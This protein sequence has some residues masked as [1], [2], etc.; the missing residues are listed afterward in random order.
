MNKVSVIIPCY[1]GESVINRSIESIYNQSYENIELIVVDDGSKDHSKELILEWKEKFHNKGYYLKYVYQNNR[2]LGGA[3]DTGLKHVT[4]VYLTL[5]DADDYYLP[6]SV[7]KRAYFL[8]N[9]LEYAAVRSNGW[10]VSGK[11]KRLFVESQN[12]K[13]ITDIFSALIFGKTNNWAGTYMV[14]SKILFDFYPE[15]SIYPSRYGQNMQ[16]MLPVAYKRKFGFIDEPLMVYELHEDSHSQAATL[17]EQFQRE[18]DNQLGYRDIYLHM[19]DLILKDSN[20]HTK[21][22]KAFEAS[23]HRC[24][25]IRAIRYKKNDLAKEHY[26]DLRLTGHINVNDKILYLDYIKNPLVYYYKFLRK[27]KVIL[28]KRGLIQ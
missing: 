3:I 15:R 5:L 21:Y 12:E 2:G 14:R 27:G 20:E 13:D 24:G 11:E 22:L 16:I 18:E 25:L 6:E 1:N 17:D 26:K 8:D 19:L 7:M 4:G 23:F 9:N 10:M 28:K